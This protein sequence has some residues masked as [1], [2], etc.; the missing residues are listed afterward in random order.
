MPERTSRI[1]VSNA[2]RHQLNRIAQSEYG[3]EQVPYGVVVSMLA[4]EFEQE[5]IR[6]H[7][8]QE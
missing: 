4:D 2:E 6:S 1:A 3:T 8:H 7:V 5:T